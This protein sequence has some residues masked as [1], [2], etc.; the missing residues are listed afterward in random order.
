MTQIFPRLIPLLYQMHHNFHYFQVWI[1]PLNTTWI[2]ASIC[3][4]QNS[5]QILTAHSDNKRICS[6]FVVYDSSKNPLR[7]LIPVALEDSILRNAVL[8][9][10]ARHLA[11]QSQSFHQVKVPMST[12]VTKFN[13]DALLFKHQAIYQLSNSLRDSK[14]CYK[15]SN[16]ASIFLLILLDLLESGG[17]EWHFHLKGAKSLITSSV[18]QL[19]LEVN[20]GAAKRQPTQIVQEIRNFVVQQIML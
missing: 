17:D 18:H 15:D 9:L 7:N 12:E 3:G 6:N 2:I 8:A 4:F 11:N 5:H 20:S 13:H 19:P 1:K 10:A 16:V 14:Q